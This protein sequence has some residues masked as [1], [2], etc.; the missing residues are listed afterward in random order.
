MRLLRNSNVVTTDLCATRFASSQT[1]GLLLWSLD[2]DITHKILSPSSEIQKVYSAKVNGVLSDV[3]LLVD[4]IENE[5][6]TA[7]RSRT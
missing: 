1:S 4:R 3:N 6:E 2:G 7:A 5:G